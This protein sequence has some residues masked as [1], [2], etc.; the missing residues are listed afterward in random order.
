[1]NATLMRKEEFREDGE[2]RTENNQERGQKMKK[3]CNSFTL[4]ELLVVIAIIAI[5]AAMLLPALSAARE[6]ARAISCTNKLK[7]VGYCIAFYNDAHEGYF[8]PTY[9]WSMSVL[10]NLGWPSI[11]MAEGMAADANKQTSMFKC[12][13]NEFDHYAGFNL[14][15]DGK[16]FTGN[17]S[18]N[19]CASPF[20]SVWNTAS[21][22]ANPKKILVAGSLNNPSKLGIVTEGGDYAYTAS[23]KTDTAI[24]FWPKYYNGETDQWWA[25]VYPHKNRV[26]VL[27]ADAHVEPISKD[28]SKKY[29]YFFDNVG[30]Y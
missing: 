2:K 7:Q 26:N 1:M 13:S 21:N 18:I 19:S 20:E 14:T 27:W 10:R 5:L 22:P 4:I 16:E 12:D 23:D 3:R 24:S 28:D 29:Y 6:N 8:P 17:Y 15:P 25:T 9:S 11:L 30:N